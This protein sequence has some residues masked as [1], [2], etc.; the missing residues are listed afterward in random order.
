[1]SVAIRV[2]LKVSESRASLQVL[3]TTAVEIAARSLGPCLSGTCYHQ[4]MSLNPQYSSKN[5]GDESQTRAGLG[6]WVLDI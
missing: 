4:P 3:S 6:L 1:M 5:T 2:N